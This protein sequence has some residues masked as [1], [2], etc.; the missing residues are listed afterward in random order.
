MIAMVNTLKGWVPR[1]VAITERVPWAIPLFGFGSGLASFFL[2]ERKEEIA[3]FI[4]V[5]MLASWCWLTLEKVLRRYFARWFGVQL[6]PPVLN[7][8]AQ[9]VHQESLFFIIPFFFITTAWNSG[10]MVFTGLLL[11]S[12]FISIIDPLYFRWLAPR[13]WLYFS[14]HGVTLF[15]VLLTALPIIFQLPTWKSYIWSLAIALA[16]TLPNVAS[17]LAWRWWQRTLAI[18]L[19][20]AVVTLLALVLRP[21]VPP[22]TLWLTEVAITQ[23]FDGEKRAPETSLKSIT[24]QQLQSGLYAYTAIHA[25][26]GLRERIYHVWTLN[27]KPI[28]KV[29]LEIN[30]GRQAGYRAWSHKVNFP[31]NSLGRWQIH[32]M[33]EA[34]QLIGVLRFNVVTAMDAAAVNDAHL[35]SS[36]ETITPASPSS[37]TPDGLMKEQLLEMT[38]QNK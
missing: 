1:V 15:A 5:M 21:W 23:Q 22:A 20:A 35:D 18:I 2:V 6:P 31:A 34:N 8:F 16:I 12:A 32:V 11:V 19:L 10:Q 9:I 14:F 38:G 25:P 4:A 28:D 24:E 37:A 27:G 7:Y 3:Q 33:T 26:R 30:G 17:E 36:A 13:R 29:A